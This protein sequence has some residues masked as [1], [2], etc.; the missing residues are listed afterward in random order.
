MIERSLLRS[1]IHLHIAHTYDL[2]IYSNRNTIEQSN[3]G[4]S[5][6]LPNQM[7]VI[8]AEFLSLACGLH[9][10]RVLYVARRKSEK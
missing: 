10:L 1:K 4:L 2:W 7:L 3:G 8:S 6:V 5:D 9:I